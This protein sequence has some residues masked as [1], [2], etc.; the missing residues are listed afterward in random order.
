MKEEEQEKL[1]TIVEEVRGRMN[2]CAGI[3]EQH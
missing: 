2:P 1:A 3:E